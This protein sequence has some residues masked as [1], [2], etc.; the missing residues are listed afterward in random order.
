MIEQD[1]LRRFLFEELG[2]RGEWVKLTTSWQAA[3]QHQ[4]GSENVQQQL[5]Q[6]LAAV[7]MLSATVKFKGS[8]ILQA[9][10]DGDIK[11]L[12]AQ[13]TDQR[14]IRGLVRGKENVTV[15]SLES[16][17][18]HG[19]LVLTIESQ[20]GHPYQGIVPLHGSNLA[21]AL[22]TYFEQSEQLKTRLWLF[23]NATHAVGLLLQELPA[24]ENYQADWEHIE[25]LANTVTEQ[26]LFDLDCEQLLYRLFHQEKVRLFDPEPVEFSCA[27]SRS[28]IEKTL[29]AMGRTELED[30]LKERDIIEVTCEFCSEHYRFDKVD[31]ENIL[32]QQN[33]ATDSETRH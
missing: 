18:G 5:G 26:E 2:V 9:Q 1:L 6:A 13:A 22:Q 20:N 21:A 23:A 10:G 25:I 27:C 8:M 4:R 31:V 16:M 3:K 11:T 15:G 14:K 30:I 32:S 7:V 24:Q 28:N 33:A 17:F 29:F 19:R 12:V